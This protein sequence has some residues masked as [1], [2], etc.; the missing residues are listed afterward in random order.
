MLPLVLVWALGS[1]LLWGLVGQD[2]I[3]YA[4]LVL[5][6]AQYGRRPWYVGLISN[7]GVLGWTTA[8]VTA[9]VGAGAANQGGRLGAA[10]LLRAGATL[11]GLLL[12]DDLF[13]LH[14]VVPRTLGQPKLLFYILY[15]G[16]GAWWALSSTRELLRTRWPLLI[17]AV[18]ALAGSV[19]VDVAGS[20]TEVA[21]VLEDSAK[22]LGIL[23]WALYFSMT[24]RDIV[25]SLAAVP[26]PA[27]EAA[28]PGPEGGPLGAAVG[29]DTA[30]PLHLTRRRW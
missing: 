2:G 17:A 20:G 15:G 21:L 1:A 18:A 13:Q 12:L 14:I 25:G 19:V 9:A 8:V 10:Q 6:P 30:R 3:P 27:S 24:T 29:P 28:H 5:D 11:S 7:L 26:N 4:D 16:L 22:F 23:A